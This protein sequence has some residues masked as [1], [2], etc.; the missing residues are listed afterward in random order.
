MTALYTV[1]Q[2]AE[3]LALSPKQV[4]FLIWAGT[5]PAV[6]FNRR[7][8]RVRAE[9]V[10][11]CLGP[12]RVEVMRAAEKG[13]PSPC[14]YFILAQTTSLVKIGSAVDVLSRLRELQTGCPVELTL[15]GA[16]SAAKHGERDLHRRFAK[17]RERGE[18]F[19][20]VKPMRDLL[21]ADAEY[22]LHYVRDMYR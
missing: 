2:V 17:Q 1:D 16:V 8:V 18:W 22:L 11:E 3:M 20:W 9:V 13:M 12:R 6:Q 14:T 4:R 5:V 21:V 15:L 7:N 10:D 19:R